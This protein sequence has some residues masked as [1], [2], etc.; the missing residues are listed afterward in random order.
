MLPLPHPVQLPY[1]LYNKRY[2]W[3]HDSVLRTLAYAIGDRIKDQNTR[4]PRPDI[5]AIRFVSAGSKPRITQRKN[6]GSGL[7]TC[8]NDWQYVVDYSGKPTIFPPSI[9]ATDQRPDIVVWSETVKMV[10]MIELTV[11]SED[12]IVDAEF[13]KKNRYDG[14]VDA[15]RLASWDA[16]LLT[17]EVGVHGF[18]AGSL[19]QCLKLL[20]VPNPAITR[21]TSAASKTALR[22]SYAIYLA[23]NNP[24]WK[25]LDL[26]MDLHSNDSTSPAGLLGHAG[27]WT[28][29]RPT[30]VTTSPCI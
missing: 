23:R 16:R 22:C 8:A 9:T 10:I 7:L 30:Q 21:T 29:T 24:A 25:P 6:P 1:S 12:N 11:P 3:R 17:I 4:Q 15:C 19:R 26:L 2:E 20:D 13:R 28:V 5:Q 27:Q 14:L 18:V